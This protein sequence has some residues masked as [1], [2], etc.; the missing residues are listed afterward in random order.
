MDL[1]VVDRLPLRVAVVVR[2]V[3]LLALGAPVLWTRSTA[4]IVV[5]VAVGAVWLLVTVLQ[6]AWHRSPSIPILLDGC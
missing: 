6:I 4:G 3:T 5:L 2:L 1:R